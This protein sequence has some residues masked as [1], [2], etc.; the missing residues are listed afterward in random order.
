MTDE[1]LKA[2]SAVKFGE[3]KVMVKR[4]SKS[5]GLSEQQIYRALRS[6]NGEQKKVKKKLIIDPENELIKEV[7]KIKAY[8]LQGTQSRELATDLC[9]EILVTRGYKEVENISDATINRRLHTIGFRDKDVIVR[10]EAEYANQTHQMD[11]SRSK[12]FQILKY[13]S[14]K[15]DYLLRCTTKQLT[16]K[17]NDTALRTW[18]VGITDTYSRLSL[19]QCYAA[20]GESLLIGIEFLNFAYTRLDENHPLCYLPDTLKTDNGAFIKNQAVKDLLD[21]YN[22]KSELVKPLKKRGIQKRESAWKRLWKRFELKQYCI[23]GE[24]KTL[25]LQDLNQLVHEE[26]ISQLKTDHPVRKGTRGHLY[27][28]SIQTREQRT[29]GDDMRITLNKY[30]RRKIDDTLC[31]T[32][33]R[34]KYQ[35]TGPKINGISVIDQ[36]VSVWLNLNGDAVAEFIDAPGKPFMMMPVD[37]F[38]NEGDFTH[39]TAPSYRQQLES[40]MQK[41]KTIYLPPRKKVVNAENK[42]D[43]AEE[44]RSEKQ[45]VF[46][47]EFEAKKYIAEQFGRNAVYKTYSE[48]FD[49]LLTDTLN[50]AD[51]D[52]VIEGIKS[53]RIAI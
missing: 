36:Q 9:K 2:L 14:D 15:G 13:D 29:A 34:Q 38:I 40:E 48:I 6:K 31:I 50:K 42:F 10:V 27:S 7:A 32:I 16:Y 21:K 39:R 35:C 44:V 52:A 25:Y 12:Y 17:E 3:R 28:T 30:Y 26:M 47:N 45:E 1:I 20:T 53:G 46:E 8:G 24:G 43:E 4:L 5:M 49:P 41:Q 18:Y 51:I 22:I 23:I 19:A 33:D 11:F 37:G